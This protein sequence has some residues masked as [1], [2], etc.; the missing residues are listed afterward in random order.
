MRGQRE[1][2]PFENCKRLAPPLPSTPSRGIFSRRLRLVRGSKGDIIS[3][4]E[5]TLLPFNVS[6]EII[7]S[8]AATT[9]IE[10]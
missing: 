6:W 1:T 10:S 8:G 2:Q 4:R 9:I 5:L 7:V 3:E